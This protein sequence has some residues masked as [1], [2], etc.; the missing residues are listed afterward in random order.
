LRD[1]ELV[2]RHEES[3]FVGTVEY[4]FKH[5]VLREVT[6]ESVP[7]RLRKTYHGLVADW[8]IANSGD[9]ISEYNGLI[10]EH[11]LL[12]GREGEAGE[13][14]FQAGESTLAAYANAEAEQFYR[15]A[16]ERSP[17]DPLRADILSGLG[18]AL[19]KLGQTDHAKSIWQEAIDLYRKL[20]D[21]DRLADVYARL[22]DLFGM[23]DA[24]KAWE[25]SQEGLEI[26]EGAPDSPGYARLLA[27]AAISAH[28]MNLPDRAI[29]LSE[30]ALEMAAKVGEVEA[31][32]KA[33]IVLAWQKAD[34]DERI[35]LIENVIMLT[36]ANGLLRT[37][38]L[39]HRAM[40]VIMSLYLVDLNS[41]LQH[42]LISTEYARKMGFTSLL[43]HA[44]SGVYV[45]NIEL[46]NLNTIDEQMVEIL[47]EASVSEARMK[48]FFRNYRP[49]LL[50]ANGDWG[51]ALD[52]FRERK[53]K[54]EPGSNT[55]LLT[56][57]NFRIAE[58]LVELN[59][60][61]ELDDLSEA[62][63]V[64]KENREIEWYL[65]PNSFLLV[66]VYVRLGLYTEAR[67]W[68]KK[69]IDLSQ[70]QESNLY[71]AL[72]ANAKFE[73]AYA[74]GHWDDATEA[75]NTSIEVYKNCGHRWRFARKLIDLGDVLAARDN[76][77]N[78]DEA[79]EIYQQSL[80]MFTEMGAPGYIKV[81][82]ERLGEMKI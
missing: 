75:C 40:R 19:A 18:E 21:R 23:V 58:T 76:P 3:A 45:D 2:F 67:T 30:R 69:A 8:L 32:A 29:F 13:Y 43:I 63:N 51:T 28:F 31:Q 56:N 14:F 68:L 81:L 52:G 57:L 42:D 50:D 17:Q 35:S 74:E 53:N 38:F 71:R 26:L 77:G 78:L 25:I 5:D 24:I 15:H 4:L 65:Y 61:G 66:I 46:G 59:R 54:L 33:G 64:L 20:G 22:S 41:A 73:L 37:A 12:A 39:A 6:Y 47:R 82:E 16:L 1:R 36:E 55:P 11:L 49:Y 48:D 60:F 27:Q 44:L 7:K 80:D 62:E 9:R 10:A 70:H 72:H 79:R 34:I